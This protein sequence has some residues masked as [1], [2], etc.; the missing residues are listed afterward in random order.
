TTYK[1][2][3]KTDNQL[4][5]MA[6]VQ[7][8]IEVGKNLSQA[9]Y[10]LVSSKFGNVFIARDASDIHDVDLY[11]VP[12]IKSFKYSPPYTGMSSHIATVELETEIFAGNGQLLRTF[13]NRQEGSRSMFNQFK[14]QT[15]YEMASGAVNEAI[16]NLLK[17]FS[18]KLDEYY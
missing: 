12:R 9:L 3:F 2:A 17:E 6:K 13:S 5:L 7:G 14:M 4:F 10:G 18:Q 8:E 15:N 16:D 1:Y 11:F